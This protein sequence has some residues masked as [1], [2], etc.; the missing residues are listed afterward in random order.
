MYFTL[1]F[2]SSNASSEDV[3]D[4]RESSPQKKKKNKIKIR[5]PRA[6]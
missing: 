3:K 6:A 2:H 5:W 4:I 1:I